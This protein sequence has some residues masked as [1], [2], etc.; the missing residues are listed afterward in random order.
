MSKS[1]IT[2]IQNY[3]LGRL[4]FSKS[5]AEL[6]SKTSLWYRFYANNYI[7]PEVMEPDFAYFL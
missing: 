4:T 3:I 1:H 5:R 2:G 6:F 7:T